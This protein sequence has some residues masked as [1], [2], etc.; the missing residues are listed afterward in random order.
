MSLGVGSRLGP[1]EGTAL[2]G[3]GMG[4]SSGPETGNGNP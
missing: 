1:Y 4:R 2:I 3:E